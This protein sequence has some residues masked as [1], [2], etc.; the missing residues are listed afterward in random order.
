[1]NKNNETALPYRLTAQSLAEI[2]ESLDDTGGFLIKEKELRFW[3]EE[4]VRR[5]RIQR[6]ERSEINPCSTFRFRDFPLRWPIVW[7]LWKL[8][9]SLEC[10]ARMSWPLA[11][12]LH[13]LYWTCIYLC[14]P[15]FARFFNVRLGKIE[16]Q[17]YNAEKQLL[18]RSV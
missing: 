5:D 18:N 12:T 15:T 13:F 9:R 11:R 16:M 1:M 14:C 17:I 7:L 8:G 6:S 3:I 4:H 10:P 2:V